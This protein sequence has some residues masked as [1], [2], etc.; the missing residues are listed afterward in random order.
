VKMNYLIIVLLTS[1][2]RGNVAIEL[3]IT[4]SGPY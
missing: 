3:D 2:K 4:G 1:N